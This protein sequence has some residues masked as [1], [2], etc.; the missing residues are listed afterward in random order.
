M[1]FITAGHTGPNSGAMGVKTELGSRFDEGKETILL[2][3]RI[4]DFLIGKYG[5]MPLLDYDNEHLAVLVNRINSSVSEN[6]ICID[7]HFNSFI[8][9]MAHGTEIILADDASE[10]EINLGVR[11]LN[12]VANTLGTVVRGVKTESQTPRHRLSMLH[13]KC[14]SLI[15]EICF[16]SNAG[17]VLKYN[18]VRDQ[19]AETI[20]DTIAY[21]VLIHDRL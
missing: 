19:L 14:R 7:I 6:D 2:R 11:L 8:S 20:A 12:R 15:L 4:A 13:L 18:S 17:D 5:I 9:S 1:I 3:N 21:E 16:C 10:A